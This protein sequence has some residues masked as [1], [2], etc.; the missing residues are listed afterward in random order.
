MMGPAKETGGGRLMTFG[1]KLTGLRKREELSQ[2][3]LAE[4]LGVSRQAVSRWEQ[5][6][7][8]P[9]AAK[10]LPCARL[11][12]VDVEWLLDEEQDGEDRLSAAEFLQGT[13]RPSVHRDWPWYIAGGIVTGAGSLGMVTMGILSAVFP[14]VVSEAPAG[15]EWVRI[16]TG[17]A[18]FL[19]AHGVEWLFALWAAVALAG[20]WLLA[21]PPIRRREQTASQFSSWYAAGVAVGLY[22]VG[23]TAWYVQLGKLRDLPLLALFLAAAVWCTVRQ[24][25]RLGGEPDETRR[26]QERIIALL[27]TVA[28]GVLLLLTAEAGFGLVALVLHIGVYFI[29][30][31]AI[32]W[33]RSGR[34]KH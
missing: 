8:L 7:A 19:K 15:V 29:C 12:S 4:Q 16:Y 18:G 2:E 24:F 30:A 21:Q 31:A 27:Y 34:G 6:A 13:E 14:V 9:D 1:E 11:F 17:L 32:T 22:G 26:R 10:L 23:Q 25:W 5:G 20:L 33:T 3:A 28:Q